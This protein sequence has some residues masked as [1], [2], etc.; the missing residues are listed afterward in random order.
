MWE[1]WAAA[2]ERR[3]SSTLERDDPRG[4]GLWHVPERE[5]H[6]LG[7][8][9]GKDVLEL[10]C[11]AARWAVALAQDGARMVGLD[12]SPSRLAQARA[13]MAAAGVD[14]PLVEASAENTPF[15]PRRFDIVFCD[16]GAVTFTDPYRTVPEVARILRPGGLFAFSNASPFRSVS[17]HR[18][19]D[20][21]SRKLLYS[22]FD[23]HRIDC[24]GEVN[25]QLPY[26]EW[27]RLFGTNS[28]VVEDLI[29]TRP[30]PRARS[31]YV[32][33]ADMAWARKWP[34]EV[35]WRVRKKGAADP[36]RGTDRPA[37]S[38]RRATRTVR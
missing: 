14:F 16:W 11:G 36:R 21:M 32:T 26:G 33:K 8:V 5:L 35:I 29:E 15:G 12:I 9:R 22:Y 4:W 2:Y 27:V 37:A 13:Q 1:R 23:L 34:M 31:T 7:A 28:L 20:Q 25:F 24:P 10:G 19:G 38:G 3:N 17:Q 18:T 6:V 30:G